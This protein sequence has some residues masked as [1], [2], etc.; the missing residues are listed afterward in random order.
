M[1]QRVAKILHENIANPLTTVQILN[2]LCDPQIR[3]SDVNRILYKTAAAHDEFSNPLDL[4]RALRLN[5][6]KESGGAPRWVVRHKTELY[7]E[8]TDEQRLC[9][10]VYNLAFAHAGV[11]V[12]IAQIAF[13]HVRV[14][15]QNLGVEKVRHILDESILRGKEK[16]EL[17]DDWDC[18]YTVPTP[19]L[20]AVSFNCDAILDARRDYT[21]AIMLGMGILECVNAN[22]GKKIFLETR[23]PGNATLITSVFKTSAYARSLNLE[24]ALLD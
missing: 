20:L 13:K 17:T 10:A 7:N 23:I 9:W 16:L 24:V 1:E 2:L 18:I 8:Y 19:P 5:Q 12:N 15:L 22:P 11:R 4:P 6:V 3:K 21:H 14:S